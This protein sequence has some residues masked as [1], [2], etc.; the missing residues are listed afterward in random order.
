MNIKKFKLTILKFVYSTYGFKLSKKDFLHSYVLF[1]NFIR[2]LFLK[3]I[4]RFYKLKYNKNILF[5][6]LI[7]S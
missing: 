2:F 6:L 3:F 1:F 7:L 4:N 5:Y